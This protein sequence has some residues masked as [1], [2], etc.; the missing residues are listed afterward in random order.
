MKPFA[1][2]AAYQMTLFLARSHLLASPLF[3]RLHSET[4]SSPQPSVPLKVEGVT[5]KL[6]LDT[7][8]GVACRREIKPERF[9]S[10][11]S[12]DMVHRLRST[13][14]AVLIGVGT[15]LKDDPSLL[16]RRNVTCDRQPL[17]AVIDPSLKLLKANENSL[18]Q[19]QLLSDG[20]RVV[21]YHC[22]KS[23]Q[24]DY[25]GKLPSAIQLVCLEPQTS[26]SNAQQKLA[27]DGIISDLRHRFGV[28]HL[29]IEGGPTTAQMFLNAGIVDRCITIMAPVTFQEPILSGISVEQLSRTFARI[30]CL[31]S[32]VDT[33]EYWSK[34]GVPW[35]STQLKDWP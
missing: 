13:A 7:S 11:E 32:G 10:P 29:M 25:A 4:D 18:H 6:A 26:S 28:R 5:L 27:V 19:F 31:S 3:I 24:E 8:R 23:A 16:V 33:V 34:P 21:I 30:G 2:A 22:Q 14:D 17:R 12:L 9:T 1:V 15:A 20:N 35:P